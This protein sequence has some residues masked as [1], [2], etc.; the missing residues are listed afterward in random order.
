LEASKIIARFL[1]RKIVKAFT[2]NFFPNR[3][4]FHVSMMDAASKMD[5]V[6]IQVSE[7]KAVFFVWDFMRNRGYDKRKVLNPR[8]KVQRCLM[9][10]TFRDGEVLLGSTTGYGPRS[11]RAR[12]GVGFF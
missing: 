8:E 3:P 4:V 10:V 1:D 2:Q 9:E 7:L 6:E 12:S 11:F 5:P